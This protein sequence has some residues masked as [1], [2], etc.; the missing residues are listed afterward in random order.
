MTDRP[1]AGRLNVGSSTME[2][3]EGAAETEERLALM[4]SEE[5]RSAF[6][7]YRPAWEMSVD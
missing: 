5:E 6:L 2:P 3:S 4:F 7:T 1:S